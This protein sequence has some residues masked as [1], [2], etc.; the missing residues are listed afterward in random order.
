MIVSQLTAPSLHPHCDPFDRQHKC[1]EAGSLGTGT[2]YTAV[3]TGTH[4]ANLASSGVDHFLKLSPI[5][6][7]DIMTR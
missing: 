7:A 4:H 5:A 2:V 1:E 6:G 3:K